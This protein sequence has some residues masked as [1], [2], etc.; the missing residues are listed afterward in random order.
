MSDVKVSASSGSGGDSS[1]KKSSEKGDETLADSS[2]Q[3]K[4]AIEATV[5]DVTS[6]VAATDIPT[7]SVTGNN[8][9]KDE[10]KPTSQDDKDN[11]AVITS[12]T[13]QQRENKERISR[14]RNERERRDRPRRPPSPHRPRQQVLTFQHIRVFY[15]EKLKDEQ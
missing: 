7:P 11:K 12:S 2:A 3:S 8:K 13:Q 4:K 15:Y 5:P 1:E 9:E 6:V 10:V 14:E